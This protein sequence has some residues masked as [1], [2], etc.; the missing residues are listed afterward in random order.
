LKSSDFKIKMDY[1]R[2]DVA[3]KEMQANL[4]KMQEYTKY[5]TLER[6]I[7]NKLVYKKKVIEAKRTEFADDYTEGTIL[8]QVDEINMEIKAREQMIKSW[9]TLSDMRFSAMCILS[10]E[11][12]ESK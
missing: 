2:R 5:I 8:D 11:I 6:F 1:N 7:I 10:N 9:V 4:E 12:K 3:E